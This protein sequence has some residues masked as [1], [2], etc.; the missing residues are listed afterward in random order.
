MFFTQ[1]MEKEPKPD[2][3]HVTFLSG[4]SAAHIQGQILLGQAENNP[5]KVM[6]WIQIPEV[7]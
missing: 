6:N 7:T 1:D 4:F 2:N 5:G 3:S